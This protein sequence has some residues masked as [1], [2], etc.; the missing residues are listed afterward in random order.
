[1]LSTLMMASVVG[2]ASAAAPTAQ[3]SGGVI[4]G[5]T[6]PASAGGVEVDQF[7]GIPFASAGRWE[8]PVDFKGKYPSQP[9][10]TS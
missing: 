4:F 2:Y 9:L 5:A 7:L 6:L 8:E 1:M 10:N 3:T